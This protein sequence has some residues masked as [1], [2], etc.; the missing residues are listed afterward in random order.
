[1]NHKPEVTQ[2]SLLS[3]Q[4]CVP[5]AYSDEEVEAYANEAN[6]AGTTHGWSIRRAGSPNFE[7]YRE[8]VPCDE[9]EGCVHLVL[10]C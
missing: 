2:R 7:G 3:M 10:D 9:R 6:P 5:E 1:M 8:R 4:V